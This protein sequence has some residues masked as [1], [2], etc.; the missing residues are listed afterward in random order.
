M[1][2]VANR[3]FWWWRIIRVKKKEGW[4][5]YDILYLWGIVRN[6]SYLGTWAIEQTEIIPAFSFFNQYDLIWNYCLRYQLVAAG[7]LLHKFLVTSTWIQTESDCAIHCFVVVF[8]N[9]PKK[10]LQKP[11][12]DGFNLPLWKM[13]KWKSVGMIFQYFSFPSWMEI[14]F[15]FQTTNQTYSYGHLLVITGY[16]WDYTVYKWGY[17]YL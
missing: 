4:K 8:K 7:S 10:G 6:V 9:S 5:P 16:K 13:M 3:V 15:M 1:S 12:V 14:K 17:K 11:L 2:V